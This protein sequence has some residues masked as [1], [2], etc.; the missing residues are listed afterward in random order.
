ML[1]HGTTMWLLQLFSSLILQWA[2]V[3]RI[4]RCTLFSCSIRLTWDVPGTLWSNLANHPER[5]AADTIWAV[6]SCPIHSATG[7]ESLSIF[8]P[9]L[10]L[11]IFLL[12][13]SNSCCCCCLFSTACHW[14]NRFRENLILS[15]LL[16]FLFDAFDILWVFKIL[17][18]EWYLR[19]LLFFEE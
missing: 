5:I 12:L 11:Y 10:C 19:V 13:I 14:R 4:Q 17:V 6:T 16:I 7:L 8:Q 15:A 1:R 18:S 3:E 9:E 2:A